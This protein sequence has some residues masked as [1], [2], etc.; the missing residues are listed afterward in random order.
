[1]SRFAQIWKARLRFIE[2]LWQRVEACEGVVVDDLS[3]FCTSRAARSSGNT[4][5]LRWSLDLYEYEGVGYDAL[6]LLVGCGS[7]WSGI[8]TWIFQVRWIEG[9][10]RFLQVEF[11]ELLSEVLEI[12]YGRPQ[13]LLDLLPPWSTLAVAILTMFD[14]SGKEWFQGNH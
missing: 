13:A 12:W 4:I 10:R 14:N 11:C 3:R 2:R 8:W 6:K 1:M 7:A 9:R 5:S